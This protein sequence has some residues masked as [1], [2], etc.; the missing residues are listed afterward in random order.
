MHSY[1]LSQWILFFFLYSFAGWIWESCYVSVKERRWV[2]R[3]FMHGPMLPIYGSGAIVVLVSTIGVRENPVLIFLMGMTGATVLE[4]ITGA[5]M[6]KLFHVRY[7]DYST[8]KFN[9]NGYICLSSSLC[10]GCFSVLLVRVVH[11][12]VEDLVLRIPALAEEW[13]AL[14]LSVTSAVDLTQSFNEAMDMKRILVQL[15]ESREQMRQ[16]QEKLKSASEEL[17]EEYRQRAAAFAEEY[18]KRAGEK[19]KERSSRKKAYL[20]QIHIR[21]EEYIHQLTLLAERAEKLLREELPE[22]ADGLTG[23]ERRRRDLE[24][25]RQNVLSE[26]QKLG[27]RTDRSYLRAA[28]QLRRNPTAASR[29]FKEALEEIRRSMDNQ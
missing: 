14:L 5:M 22:K 29:K 7:W 8:Q 13:I 15:E 21:R 16:M 26:L 19:A 2:N 4:Y 18:R 12:P 1:H 9:L 10:W 23:R 24:S 11:V 25:I 27:E 28:R 17:A 3:G 6:E 20:G